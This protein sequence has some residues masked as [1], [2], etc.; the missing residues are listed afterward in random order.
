LVRI[1]AGFSVPFASSPPLTLLSSA[2]A[3]AVVPVAAVAFSF[4]L[5]DFALDAGAGGAVREPDGVLAVDD[6]A[7]AEEL[8][9]FFFPPAALAALAA[10]AVSAAAVAVGLAFVVFA[11][12]EGAAVVGLA[13]FGDFDFDFGAFAV[14]ASVVLAPFEV[15]GVVG[16]VDLGD[17]A[18]GDLAFAFAT[19]GVMTAAEDLGVFGPVPVAAA[20]DLD[21]VR[22]VLLPATVLVSVAP[23]LPGVRDRDRATFRRSQIDN[24]QSCQRRAVRCPCSLRFDDASIVLFTLSRRFF[25]IS[26]NCAADILHTAKR[27]AHGARI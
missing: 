14:A 27:H 23:A 12:V 25:R 18:F 8:F 17:L 9:F 20:G 6:A 26:R 3:V 1:F 10:L 2:V 21:G 19:F 11:A 24:N 5:F 16:S 22:G 13:A 7:A 15:P 4:F